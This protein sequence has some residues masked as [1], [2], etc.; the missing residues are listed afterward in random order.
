MAGDVEI[1]A[2]NRM[3]SNPF[4]W[5]THCETSHLG[6]LSAATV[7]Q[8]RH[9]SIKNVSFV[10]L[11]ELKDQRVARDGRKIMGS[12]EGVRNPDFSYKIV[13][14]DEAKCNAGTCESIRF[15]RNSNRQCLKQSL[16]LPF[17]K[18]PHDFGFLTRICG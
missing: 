18:S 13:N 8:T 12:T 3:G 2:E 17:R 6:S 10:S 16:C 14:S 9:R 5:A 4:N 7:E 1:R 15:T 11:V